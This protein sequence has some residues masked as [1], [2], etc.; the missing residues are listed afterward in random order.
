MLPSN[1]LFFSLTSNSAITRL[2]FVMFQY[3]LALYKEAFTQY[4][5]HKHDPR[6]INH[7]LVSLQSRNINCLHEYNQTVSILISDTLC[8]SGKESKKNENILIKQLHP[9][10]ALASSYLKPKG[11]NT[12]QYIGIL[13]RC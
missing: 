1:H 11:S 9:L 2:I 12:E 8:L 5:Y 4:R 10:L 13:T 3:E 6:T 7:D